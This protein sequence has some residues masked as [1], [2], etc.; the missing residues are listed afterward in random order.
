MLLQRKG[1]SL[2]VGEGG[3]RALP[4]KR[5]YVVWIRMSETQGR[6]YS[7]FLDSEQV[8]TA[9][10]ESRS[11]LAA[12]TVLKVRKKRQC[13]APCAFHRSQNQT[14]LD[15]FPKSHVNFTV[16]RTVCLNYLELRFFC[17][18]ICDHPN[19]LVGYGEG[20]ENEEG[21]ISGV[22]E[23]SEV[24]DGV[25]G[26]ESRRWS[27]ATSDCSRRYSEINGAIMAPVSSGSLPHTEKTIRSLLDQSGKLQFAV[28]LLQQFKREGHKWDCVSFCIPSPLARFTFHC[29]CA[30]QIK[31]NAT[32]RKSKRPF[33]SGRCCSVSA[34]KCSMFWKCC[35][36]TLG[37]RS[38]GS[39]AP[40][41][42]FALLSF[43][44]SSQ[45]ISFADE[46]SGNGSSMNSTR[47]LRWT[48]S[49]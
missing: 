21:A 24:D 13:L 42:S 30:I 14:S 36:F 23:E 8:H 31:S 12:L 20:G 38:S 29:P 48:C 5:D 44:K 22:S 10:N 7:S 45:F 49:S 35:S 16:D 3:V 9:M 40:S 2:D 4:T 41:Q 37:S 47:V 11:P 46:G 32:L 34:E 39:T 27:A 1:N 26:L 15:T 18:K 19:L 43:K 17:Q 6:L 25:V 33:V 28:A